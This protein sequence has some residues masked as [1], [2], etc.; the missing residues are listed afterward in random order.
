M[1]RMRKLENVPNVEYDS[2]KKTI[3]FAEDYEKIRKNIIINTLSFENSFG[4][5]G[6]H[7][8]SLKFH[9]R[10]QV[11]SGSIRGNADFATL[12]AQKTSQTSFSAFSFSLRKSLF[13]SGVS[14]P[15]FFDYVRELYD[16]FGD[17]FS[18]QVLEINFYRASEYFNH[19]EKTFKTELLGFYRTSNINKLPNITPKSLKLITKNGDLT[20]SDLDGFFRFGETENEHGGIDGY[21]ESKSI[22]LTV[23]EMENPRA[24]FESIL[25][26][27]FL[28]DIQNLNNRQ[29]ERLTFSIRFD[30]YIKK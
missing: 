13:D 17:D 26:V 5:F 12:I 8:N 22:Y 11:A 16:T 9:S 18:P 25:D 7:N 4:F 28:A 14:L 21:V 29:R 10:G 24:F 19:S 23:E 20:D 27:E 2:Q 30:Y 3:L 1:Y 15:S 6:S